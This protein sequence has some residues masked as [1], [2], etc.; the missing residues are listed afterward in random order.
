MIR[1]LQ[2]PGPLKKVILGGMLL[3]ICAAMVVTLIPGGLGASLGLTGP[4]RGVVARVSGEEVTTLEVQ[5]A[6]RQM[7]QQQFPR[8]GAQASMLLPFFAQRAADQLINEKVAL[9]E[10]QHLGL[11]A[12]EADVRD[13]LQHGRY[14]G[15]FFPG[16]KFIGEN[17]Y[18]QLL[19]QH[20]L[21]VPV[22]EQGVKD[23]ILFDKLR[24]LVAGSAAVSP[25]EVR[26]QFEKQSS[27][28]KFDYAV[29]RK[30]DLL[31]EIHPS[32]SELKAFYD[33]NKGTYTNSIPEKR[34][35][36]YIVIDTAS[37]AAQT[38]VSQQDL[39]AYYDQHREDYR[40]PE[41]V[42][43]RHIL[44]KSPLPG[45]DG[46]VDQKAAD[47]ARK[48][49]E[50]VLKQVKAG[51]NFAELAKKYSEDPGSAKNGGSLG[52]IGRGRTVPEFEKAAFSLPKGSTRDLVQSSYG[53]H[54]I[55][56]DDK[57][58]AHLKTLD[59]VKAQIEPSLK[60]QKATQAAESQ[61]NALLA[62][63][64]SEGLDK[65]AAAK[66][67]HAVATD[68]VTRTD[69]LPGIGNAPQFMDAVFSEREKAPPSEAPLPQGFAIF[70]VLASKPPSTPTFEEI[71]SRV[72]NEFKNERSTSLLTQ[73]TQEL[74]DR[75]KAGHNLKKVA[76]ELG[77]TVKTSDL[78]L[79]DGQVPDLGAM[80]G[81]ASVAFTLKPGEISGPVNNGNTGAVLAVV[82]KQEPSDQDFSS[83][84]DQVRDALLQNKQAE[85]FGI[86]VAGLRDQME[87]SGKIKINQDEM[88]GLTKGQALEGG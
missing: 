40:Q 49:A 31:K 48:K 16:G 14:S 87:K 75:A 28:V 38:P 44:I 83:K 88:K 84:K 1:F 41:Q 46:K 71:R 42:N 54:I 77:A 82:E 56:V 86:F 64:K 10:A 80:S 23:E 32:E 2:T 30:D 62:Q 7:V 34:Q 4:G 53:F 65:A 79:P 25:A 20:D 8:G 6:A 26:Q 61:A 52:P 76:K 67:Q 5:R 11:R 63:A 9:A 70:E 37:I 36:K 21:T 50:D 59:E 29:L 33:R 12:T 72:E 68:F 60:Q 81:A 78:V 3:V 47:E 57:Q 85:A 19:Q 22:F 24:T 27:K 18:Q 55:H 35:I 58:D 43:V 51:G 45:P 13:E 39:Q 17:E 73:K 74:A 15:T 66:G 69:S